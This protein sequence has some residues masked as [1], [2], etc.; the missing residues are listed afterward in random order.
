VWME[1]VAAVGLAAGFGGILGWI[2]ASAR[3]R[4]AS[5]DI[6]RQ[7]EGRAAAAEAGAQELRAQIGPLKAHADSLT[8]ALRQAEGARAAA[9]ARIEEMQR[10]FEQQRATLE[11]DRERLSETF[12]A[13]AAETLRVTNEDF[14]KL[15]GERLG[16]VQKQTEAGLVSAQNA[17]A[18]IVEPVRESLSRVDRQL[19][20]I[21]GTRRE[22]YGK[23]TE[24]VGSLA[25]AQRLLQSETANLAQALKSP[26]VRGRW[27]EVQL[28]RVVE[29]AGMEEY[30]DFVEQTG[31]GGGEG[32]ARPDM[33][34]NLTGGRQIAVDA[35]A[36]LQ[37]YLEALEAPSEEVQ[38]A[39]LREHSQ[40]VRARV[41]ELAS[42]SYAQRLERSVE[43]VVLFIPGEVFFSA[44]LRAAPELIEESA[45]KGIILASPT[46]LLAMLKA[47]AYGWREQRMADNAQRI[48]EMGRELHQRL[49]TM[50]EHMSRLGQ[51]L[52]KSVEAF[53]ATI[54]SFNY[55]VMPSAQRLADLGAAGPRDLPDLEE[56]DN[57]PRLVVSR[58]GG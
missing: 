40:Q 44:A 39:K 32:G 46:T 55:R 56:V 12:K 7:L 35:K 31:I 49:T 29:L 43:F 21:E 15:A 52:E 58:G 48:S 27:G 47:V 37:A 23:L 22:A 6:I 54:G 13:L 5:Q 45:N 20:E 10:G 53:N 34:I 25:Q 24:Q 50:V 9:D 57:R 28:R 11:Q 8:Q 16:A 17:I 36:S 14:L 42:K 51:S 33:I 4:A 30:C 1:L 2:L 41:S 19:Q 3:V 26:V 38:S 18:G